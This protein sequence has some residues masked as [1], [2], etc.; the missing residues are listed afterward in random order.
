MRTVAEQAARGELAVGRYGLI[1]VIGA[2]EPRRSPTRWLIG[3]R[4]AA[5]ALLIIAVAVAGC[6]RSGKTTPTVAPERLNSILLSA[7]DVNAVMGTS[8]MKLSHRAD[9]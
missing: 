1:T 5:A 3:T 4:T 6:G 8:D 7:A 9:P 2:G